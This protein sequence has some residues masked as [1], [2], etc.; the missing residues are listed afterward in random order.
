MLLPNP[1]P[2][3][4][5]LSIGIQSAP[6]PPTLEDLARLADPI[7]VVRFEQVH[8]FEQGQLVQVA[9]AS[10]ERCLLGKS[11][12]QHLV[13]A[14]KRSQLDEGGTDVAEGTRAL[15][16][17]DP[18][19][20]L[21][22]DEALVHWIVKVVGPET[23]HCLLAG[24]LWR[25]EQSENHDTVRIPAPVQSLPEELRASAAERF[26]AAKRL[27]A[28]LDAE[29]DRIT[30][31]AGATWVTNGVGGPGGGF[32]I[33]LSPEG[34]FHGTEQ[35]RLGP[36]ALERFWQTVESERFRELPDLVGKSK[37]PDQSSFTAWIRDRSGQHVVRIFFVPPNDLESESARDELARALR[38]WSAFPGSKR[39]EPP[40]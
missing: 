16:F 29:L 11:S 12:D 1:S 2:W 33:E 36:D 25:L 27:L 15:V 10:V 38:V 35:G 13:L 20:A 4:L 22:P 32:R 3:L 24:G 34:E 9:R 37:H 18:R 40:R 39:P 5:L 7:A 6:T 30:P 28:W 21:G 23:P 31:S 19:P 17:V 26:L 8:Q 14:W